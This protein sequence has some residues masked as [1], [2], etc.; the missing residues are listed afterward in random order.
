MHPELFHIGWFT[1]NS[2]GLMMALAFISAGFVAYWQFGKRGVR[3][4]FIY[5]LLIAA[6]VGGLL[7]AK[8]HYLILHSSEWPR[9][10]LSGSGLVWFGGLFGAIIGVVVVTV[11]FSKERLSRVMDAGAIAVSVGYAVGRIGCFL[12][13]DDYGVPTNLPWGMSFPKG[14]PPTTV[15]VHPAQLYE[16]AASLVIFALLVWVVSPRFKREGPLIFAYAILA[17]IERFLVE[18]IRTNKPVLLGLTQQQWIAIGMIVVGAV[19]TW[20]FA[21]RG[22]MRPLAEAV[23][24]PPGGV[25][26]GPVSVKAGQVEPIQGKPTVN[27]AAPARAKAARKRGK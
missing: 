9:N 6:V 19:F 24:A 12:T 5:G 3:P 21:T 23:P 20:Y 8:I 11:F 13:G 10:L 25:P 27:K 14:S 16:S 15:K 7:G 18:F 4:D 1:M 22:R 17:G 26:V 2:F